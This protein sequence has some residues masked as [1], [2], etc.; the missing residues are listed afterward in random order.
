MGFVTQI[1]SD[2]GSILVGY[3]RRSYPLV[4]HGPPRFACAECSEQEGIHL[5]KFA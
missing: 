1:S 2:M 5:S 4:L 3:A